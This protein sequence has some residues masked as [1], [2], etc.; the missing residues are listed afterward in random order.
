MCIRARRDSI[1]CDLREQ[2]L[3]QAHLKNPGYFLER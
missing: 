2:E 1:F 3:V